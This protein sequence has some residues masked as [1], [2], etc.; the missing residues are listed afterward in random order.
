MKIVNRHCALGWA[1]DRFR[2]G[3]RIALEEKPG[4]Q[5]QGSDSYN[6]YC[7]HESLLLRG[8]P[9]A[10]IIVPIAQR[11]CELAHTRKISVAGERGDVA[12]ARLRVASVSRRARL[13][14]RQMQLCGA[15][16]PAQI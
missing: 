12:S 4:G 15:A 9:T 1:L 3:D 11:V 2:V 6:C 14:E 5:E 10:Q 13:G 7:P 8:Y 16:W